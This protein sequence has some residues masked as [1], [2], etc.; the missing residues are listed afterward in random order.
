MSY[1]PLAC[2]Y[3]FFH[4]QINNNIPFKMPLNIG[5]FISVCQ[6]SVIYCVPLALP[7]PTEFSACLFPT[8]S[9]D[10]NRRAVVDERF[11]LRAPPWIEWLNL[12]LDGPERI[13]MEE[14]G[15]QLALID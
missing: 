12:V 4:I 3:I 13:G 2:M 14:V 1:E 11:S 15:F 8:P 9:S 10:R 6:P 5:C 7:S